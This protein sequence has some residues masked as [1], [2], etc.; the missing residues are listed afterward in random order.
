MKNSL[1]VILSAGFLVLGI[2]EFGLSQKIPAQK[3]PNPASQPQPALA[4]IATGTQ[5]ISRENQ[6]IAI[7]RGSQN[8]AVD[9]FT[10][11]VIARMTDDKTD[12]EKL[13]GETVSPSRRTK[14]RGKWLVFRGGASDGDT[15]ALPENVFRIQKVLSSTVKD[16][17]KVQIDG[18]VYRLEPGEV[19][20]L[21]G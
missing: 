16:Q 12:P 7:F 11:L 18:R 6:T 15:L 8:V 13:S 3:N 14:E 9:Y 4:S 21:L 5:R 17:V 19:L 20:L 2:S 10:E 1:V